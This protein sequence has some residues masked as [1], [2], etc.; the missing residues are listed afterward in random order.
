MSEQFTT[1]NKDKLVS[2]LRV[3]ISDTAELL[4][5]TAGAAGEPGGRAGRHR[6]GAGALSARADFYGGD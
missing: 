6:A 1:A 4:R 3:V 5:A 2:D